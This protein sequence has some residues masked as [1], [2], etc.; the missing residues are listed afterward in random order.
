LSGAKSAGKDTVAFYITGCIWNKY[1]QKE[2][3]V[4]ANVW[5]FASPLKDF[6]INVMG[7]SEKQC[8]GSDAEKNSPTKYLWDNLTMSIRLDNSKETVEIPVTEDSGYDRLYEIKDLPRTGPMTA[9]EVMQIFGTDIMRNM[10]SNNIWT[11]ATLTDIDNYEIPKYVAI[12]TDVR[13][14]SEVEAI[15]SRENGFVVRLLR[16]PYNDN[17]KSEV[18]LNNYDFSK[19]GDKVLVLDNEKMGINATNVAVWDFVKSKL[20]D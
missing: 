15:L 13:F 17:H 19:Y 11:D 18:E 8:Y 7:L 5:S 12:I 4:E 3:D 2:S 14:V 1:Y 10:F 16:K 20:K 6:L 9:R